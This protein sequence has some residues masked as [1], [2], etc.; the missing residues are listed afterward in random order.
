M[1]DTSAPAAPRQQILSMQ[2]LPQRADKLRA[3]A[4]LE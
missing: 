4:M 1:P 3:N 2:S